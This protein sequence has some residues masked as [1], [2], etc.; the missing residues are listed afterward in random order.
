LNQTIDEIT[1]SLEA[2]EL[3]KAARPFND[4]T[5]DLSTWYL[6]RSRD[7]FKGS[8]EK[9]K[10]A[11]LDSTRLVLSGLAKLLA[12]FMP[13]LAEDIFLRTNPINKESVHLEE[14]PK[15]GKIDS[16]LLE[17]MKATRLISSKGLEARMNAK[18]N[19]RQP[20]AS[21]KI[22]GGLKDI[23]GALPDSFIE[24]IK[25]EVN[26]KSVSF[27]ANIQNDIELDLNITPELKEEGMVRELTRVIQDLRKEKGLNVN[28]AA[29][30]KVE[31]NGAG[32][33]FIEKNEKAIMAVTALKE[34]LFTSSEGESVAIGEMSFKF[35]LEKS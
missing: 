14:W 31:T 19:V 23:S 34:V 9:D 33:A 6:R 25:D 22:R 18:I 3:D 15:A 24:L 16:T 13:F 8:D 10:Q 1:A 12:P 28:D 20:L 17:N 21:L 30:L 29:S 26:V 11:A 4:L 32:R 5:D 7:R 2:G 35:G 27:N